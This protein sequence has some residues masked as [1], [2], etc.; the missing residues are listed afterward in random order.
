MK[1]IDKKYNNIKKDYIIRLNERFKDN[2]KVKA[3]LLLTIEKGDISLLRKL[4][5]DLKCSVVFLKCRIPE[6]KR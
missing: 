3:L 2:G 4:L 1:F 5:V 6:C